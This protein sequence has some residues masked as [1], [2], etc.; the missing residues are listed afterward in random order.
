[1]KEWVTGFSD[2][3]DDSCERKRCVRTGSVWSGPPRW[4]SCFLYIR[5][6][7]SVCFSYTL[8][9]DW[10]PVYFAQAPSNDSSNFS[11]H[12]NSSKG[13]RRACSS[14]G[15]SGNWWINVTSIPLISGN[16]TFFPG[17]RW[18]PY[19]VHYLGYAVGCHSKTLLQTS[20]VPLSIKPLMF[21]ADSRLFLWS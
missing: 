9:P 3:S 20:K 13:W 17:W 7:A 15:F 19:S 14:A 11:H 8:L 1:M 5:C 2:K 4:L 10:S 6:S 12:N 16:A 18:P 21:V